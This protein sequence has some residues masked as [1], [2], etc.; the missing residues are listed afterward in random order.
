MYS[1]LLRDLQAYLERYVAFQNPDYSFAAALWACGTHLFPRPKQDV[2]GNYTIPVVTFDAYPYLVITSDTKRSGKTRFSEVEGNLCAR[3]RNYTG[4][5]EA[6]IYRAIRNDCPTMINDEAELLAGEG[7]NVLTAVLNA[8]YRRGQTVPR[9]RGEEIIEWPL[10]CPK[11]FVLIG[12]VRDTLRDRSIIIRM[13]RAEPKERFVFEKARAE[14]AELHAQLVVIM[15]KERQRVSDIYAGHAGITFLSD[16]DEEIW[17]PLFALCEAMAPERVEELKRVAVDMATEKTAPKRRY[18]NLL[19]SGAEADADDTEYSRKLLRDMGA[20]YRRGEKGLFTRDVL[21]R[22]YELTVAPWRKYRGAGLT[23]I[24]LAD[25]LSRFGLAPKLLK[26]KG[27][28]ARGYKR[29]D[30]DRAVRTLG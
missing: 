27:V 20:I 9:S 7:Q 3:A 6:N 12:D 22:L 16:R 25:M 15:E 17:L 18:V 14:G 26:I 2:E 28:A 4:A 30:V 24:N 5:K 13:R 11:M 1:K 10:Y 29:A 8:G 21:P 19:E 23:D